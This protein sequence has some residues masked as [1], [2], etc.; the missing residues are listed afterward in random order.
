MQITQD[1]TVQIDPTLSAAL[2]DKNRLLQT[3][4]DPTVT[5]A[6]WQFNGEEGR[7]GLNLYLSDQTGSRSSATIPPLVLRNEVELMLRLH[8]LNKAIR[9]VR[10]WRHTV[11]VLFA[12]LRPWCIALPGNPCVQEGSGMVIEDMSGGYDVPELMVIRGNTAM[13]ITP[14]GAWVLG[15]DGRVDM[16][17][18]NYRAVLQYTRATDQW[19]HVPDAAP[20]RELPLTEPLFRELAEACLDD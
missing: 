2:T 4:I 6:V 1:V 14:V 3:T 18:P 11:A 16:L 5:N 19:Y 20:Y 8:K 13:V 12:T 17:G 10:D 9:R 15:A 7:P